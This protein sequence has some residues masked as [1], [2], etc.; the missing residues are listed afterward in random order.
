MSIN[1]T[2]DNLPINSEATFIGKQTSV[3]FNPYGFVLKDDSGKASLDFT[4]K[5]TIADINKCLAIPSKTMLKVKVRVAENGT[6]EILE[7]EE[8]NA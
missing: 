4:E 6:F 1:L 3:Y 5:H 7:I 2:N 8:L